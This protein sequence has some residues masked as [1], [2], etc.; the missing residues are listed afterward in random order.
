MELSRY[1]HAES[2]SS[3]VNERN[4]DFSTAIALQ[5]IAQIKEIA[6][7]HDYGDEK[8][9]RDGDEGVPKKASFIG[10]LVQ[11]PDSVLPKKAV[12][13]ACIPQA[14]FLASKTSLMHLLS[15]NHLH[16]RER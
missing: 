7:R 14:D 6:N 12:G 9:D 2:D 8:C 4:G 1:Y 11:F 10:V 5:T 13:E 16:H 3:G 15:H